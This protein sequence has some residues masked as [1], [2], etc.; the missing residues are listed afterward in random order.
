VYELNSVNKSLR[1]KP[2]REP[3]ARRLPHLVVCGRSLSKHGQF[4]R[5]RLQLLR[6]ALLSLYINRE[7]KSNT[8]LSKVIDF[9]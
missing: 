4:S 3:D 6:D 1:F 5:H 2:R 9:P 8:I 7:A